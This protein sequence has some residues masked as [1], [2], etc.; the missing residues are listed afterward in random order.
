MPHDVFISYSARDKAVAEAACAA[1]EGRGMRCWIAP[2][3]VLPGLAYAAALIDALKESRV[4]V[5]VFSSHSND[6]PQVQREVERAVSRGVPIIPFRIEEVVPSKAM[7]YYISTP[8]WLDALTPPVGKHL[9]RLA[10]TVE[11]LLAQAGGQEPSSS[12][13]ASR[14]TTT[15]AGAL[16]RPMPEAPRDGAVPEPRGWRARGKMSGRAVAIVGIAALLAAGL[17]LTMRNAGRRAG[18][19]PTPSAVRSSVAS[20]QKEPARSART[21][22][23]TPGPVPLQAYFEYRRQGAA[24]V[25]RIRLPS[26]ES[27]TLTPEDDYRLSI[28][29]LEACYLYVFQ[30]DSSGKTA[31]LFPDPKRTPR[32]S[33]PVSGH[34]THVLPAQDAWYYLDQT[35]GHETLSIVPSREARP[36]L[37]TVSGQGLASGQWS[38]APDTRPER[39]KTTVIEFRF[40]HGR[41]PSRR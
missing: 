19:E 14:Q 23:Q 16:D 21:K 27:L 6:S 31:R 34:Q 7:E 26:A 12:A 35:P 41:S 39:G 33:N 20:D 3:D 1:L 24:Q 17:L 38:A 15:S 40:T 9:P 32:L 8:H 28:E 13:D 29:P 37:E 36:D 30:R 2:R 10:E 18:S 11:A 25:T 22:A 5:L 4:F